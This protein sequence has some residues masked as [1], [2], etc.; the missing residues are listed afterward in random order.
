MWW[1][2]AALA[3]LAGGCSQASD[4]SSIVTGSLGSLLPQAA[5]SAQPK[6]PGERISTS[7]YRVM[8]TDRKFKDAIERENYTLLK[9][10][11]TTRAVGGT[12]FM[13]V[14]AGDQSSAGL[15]TLASLSG[16]A[17]EF[18]AY[19]RVLTL[20]PGAEAPIGAV[21]AEE[22]IHFFGPQFARGATG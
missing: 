16:S 21:H 1:R 5:P 8:A 20:D 17:T 10:A 11:E 7:L 2:T 6:L 14:K 22:I 9:A 13:L 15:P 19:I 3:L 12:H 18:G 4:G